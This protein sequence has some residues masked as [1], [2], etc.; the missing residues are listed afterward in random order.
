MDNLTGKVY[1]DI[2][3][4]TRILWGFTKNK[5]PVSSRGFALTEIKKTE[6]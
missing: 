6:S 5:S 4:M 2:G 3:N 1:I